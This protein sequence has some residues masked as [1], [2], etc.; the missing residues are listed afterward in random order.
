MNKALVF[1]NRYAGVRCGAGEAPSGQFS[2]QP[3]AALHQDATGC[4]DRPSAASHSV[5][6]A[7]RLQIHAQ[8]AGFRYTRD[9]G[10]VS[11]TDNGS[12]GY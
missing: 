10:R 3:G 4:A 2:E 8:F 5:L 11:G 1:C 7:P 9:V 12:N 6:A